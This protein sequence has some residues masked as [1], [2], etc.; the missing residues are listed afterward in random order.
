MKFKILE[1]KSSKYFFESRTRQITEEEAIKLLKTTHSEAINSAPIYRGE[2]M[3]EDDYIF[4]T[5]NPNNLRTSRNT[6]NYYTLIM[7][8]AEIWKRF[9]KRQI[10]C[11]TEKST[12]ISYG[13]GKAYR[14]F[15]KNGAKIGIVHKPDIWDAGKLM[16]FSR[17]NMLVQNLMAKICGGDDSYYSETKYI[18]TYEDLKKICSEIDKKS[19]TELKKF[20][21]LYEEY[22]KEIN[23]SLLNFLENELYGPKGFVNYFEVKRIKNFNITNEVT[24]VW[25]DAP[26]LLI[27]SGAVEAILNNIGKPNEI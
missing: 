26:S 13:H 21:T 14:V 5:P 24:E 2:R 12:A 20:S 16:K 17:A 4:I 7:N 6:V 11:T 1:M 10:I 8:N 19:P 18:D 22:A 25:T 23:G 27:K 9:P 15:P 3:F